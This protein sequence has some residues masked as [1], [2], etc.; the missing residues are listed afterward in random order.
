MGRFNPI[1]AQSSWTI[2]GTSTIG[3]GVGL[4][5]GAGG[6]IKMH[7]PSGSEHD[8]DFGIF[9]AGPSFGFKLP[10]FNVS[11]DATI[12]VGRVYMTKDFSGVELTP[13]DLAGVC[14]V[15]DAFGGLS[16]GVSATAI[17][18]QVSATPEGVLSH[19]DCLGP[20]LPICVG[21]DVANAILG[22][23]SAYIRA[24]ALILLAGMTAGSTAGVGA[25]FYVGYMA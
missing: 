4:V 21:R 23:D 1:K 15:F 7:D 5:A 22:N 2:D 24:N 20:N 6:V 18:A 10:N 25:D 19:V 14:L 8:F 16:A 12:T 3:L 17:L 11:G 9:G 13:S